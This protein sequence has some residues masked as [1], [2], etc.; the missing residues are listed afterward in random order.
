VRYVGK[1]GSKL[2]DRISGLVTSADEYRNVYIDRE[3]KWRRVI[4][5]AQAAM[6]RDP[7]V[8]AAPADDRAVHLQGRDAEARVASDRLGYLHSEPYRHSVN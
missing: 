1:E 8:G 7:D 4:R 2:D 5:L 6:D 3:G